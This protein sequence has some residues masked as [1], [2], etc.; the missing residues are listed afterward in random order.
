MATL[1]LDL[2][3]TTI[4]AEYVV[5]ETRVGGK[6]RLVFGLS[7]GVGWLQVGQVTVRNLTQ[8]GVV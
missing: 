1:Q 3:P 7:S 8:L 4:Y 2:E 5:T 6:P